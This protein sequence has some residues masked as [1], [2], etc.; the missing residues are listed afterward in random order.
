[1]PLTNSVQVQVEKIKL[2]R[3]LTVGKSNEKSRSDT[4]GLHLTKSYWS[5]GTP[6]LL[7]RSNLR[8]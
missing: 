4:K 3:K 6:I 8:L 1:M 5:T 7:Y 2:G